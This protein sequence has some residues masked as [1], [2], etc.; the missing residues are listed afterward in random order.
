MA[1]LWP[2][3]A[4]ENDGVRDFV[5]EQISAR[6]DTVT[7]AAVQARARL[8]EESI[9]DLRVAI[10]RTKEAMRSLAAWMEPKASKRLRRALRPV[11]RAAGETRNLDVARLLCLESPIVSAAA[12]AATLSRLRTGSAH[13]LLE[14]LLALDLEALE[15]P[16]QPNPDAPGPNE[17]A[18]Q[19]AP[20]LIPRYWKAGDAAAKPG[21][22]A[23]A[24]HG[25]RL[26]TKHLRY[27]LE[28]FTPTFGRGVAAKLELLRRVQTHLGRANDCQTARSLSPVRQDKELEAWIAGIQRNECEKFIEIWGEQRRRTRSGAT[29]LRYF[30]QRAGC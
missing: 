11:M 9:H 16:C 1:A 30:E 3:A 21:A 27:T 10:R 7:A 14:R 18:A 19:L 2:W 20:K 12:V 15:P 28:L 26:A 24:L 5:F 22:D 8:D 4:G 13:Q 6:V 25:F 17:L 29:W 23:A